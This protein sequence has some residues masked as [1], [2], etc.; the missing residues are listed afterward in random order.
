MEKEE[1]RRGTRRHSISTYCVVV[2][3][4]LLISTVQLSNHAGDFEYSDDG[5][6]KTETIKKKE[7]IGF[8]T[9]EHNTMHTVH[10]K[11]KDEN[12]KEKMKNSKKKKSILS[13]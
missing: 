4:L 3:Y 2:R 12:E 10:V 6:E 1:G 13:V 9:E 7:I 8:P 5:D 11:K